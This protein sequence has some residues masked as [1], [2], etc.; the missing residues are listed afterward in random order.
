MASL[1]SSALDSSERLYWLNQNGGEI[2]PGSA[3]LVGSG[4][5][6]HSR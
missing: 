6:C 1:F 2:S 5:W 3:G 4:L